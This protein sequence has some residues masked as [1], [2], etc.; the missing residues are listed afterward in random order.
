[1]NR[2]RFLKAALGAAIGAC[3]PLPVPKKK[4]LSMEVIREATKRVADQGHIFVPGI[5]AG[6]EGAK[7]DLFDVEPL[8]IVMT[9]GGWRKADQR[10]TSLKPQIP[11]SS[12]E[13]SRRAG[14]VPA[15]F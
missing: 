9:E 13:A 7:V 6:M 14:P 10:D 11:N 3:V 8:T 15:G 4:P 12:C 2:R 5:W 1:M